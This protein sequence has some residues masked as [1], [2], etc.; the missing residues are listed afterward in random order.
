LDTKTG[1]VAASAGLQRRVFSQM[2]SIWLDRNA[3]E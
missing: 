3:H 1:S 2:R